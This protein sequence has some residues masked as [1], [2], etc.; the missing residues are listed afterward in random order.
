MPVA[1]LEHWLA[2]QATALWRRRPMRRPAQGIKVRRARSCPAPTA[3]PAPA[4][5]R[6]QAFIGAPGPRDAPSIRWA[7]GGGEGFK[8]R[9]PGRSSSEN[10][11]VRRL[12]LREAAKASKAGAIFRSVRDPL[13]GDRWSQ[14]SSAAMC[15]HRT[16]GWCR[17]WMAERR[18]GRTTCR[19]LVDDLM[20]KDRRRRR[21]GTPCC[22]CGDL[23]AGHRAR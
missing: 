10:A 23:P 5:H 1:E 6:F 18:L 16:R 13:R 9:R 3:G 2:E 11:A 22:R 15:G 12:T 8:D 14:E 20:A 21:S 4:G 19:A 17:S 7:G